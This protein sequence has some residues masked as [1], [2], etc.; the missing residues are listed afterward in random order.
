MS[1][2]TRSTVSGRPISLL[3]DSAAAHGRAGRPSTWASRSLVL[4]LPDEP[5]TPTT[6]QLG[7]AVDH[8]AREPRRAPPGRRRR[9]R[10]A[11]LGHRPLGQRPRRRPRSTAC[12]DEVVAVDVLAPPRDEQAARARTARASVDDRRRPPRSR[13]SPCSRAPVAAAISARV[14]GDHGA[15]PRAARAAQLVAVVERV[16]DAGDLLAR[17]VPLARDQQR[18]RRAAADGARPRSMARP[19]VADLEHLD[20]RPR[21]DGAGRRPAPRRGSRPGPPSAGCRRSRR[22]RRRR[23]AAAAPMPGRLPGSR[24]PPAPSTTTSRPDA[25]RAQRLQGG[26]RP[27][28]GCAR[29]RRRRAGRRPGS[30][31]RSIRPG[32]AAGGGAGPRRTCVGGQPGRPAASPRPAPR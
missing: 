32:H 13:R 2:S 27:R 8:L 20:G 11:Q 14:S 3:N 30:P 7:H 15:A 22:R 5:V 17:L 9:P 21:R 6:A 18:R 29:S 19:A 16:H 10:V 4:V 28:P 26:G 23:R 1:G 25:G 24:S 31:T 12:G